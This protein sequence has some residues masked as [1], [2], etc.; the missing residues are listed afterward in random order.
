M[1]VD[2]LNGWFYGRVCDPVCLWNVWQ[3]GKIAFCICA[4]CDTVFQFA[5]VVFL[6]FLPQQMLF[7]RTLYQ[8]VIV[9]VIDNAYVEKN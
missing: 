6:L 7:Q 1:V 9:T 5:L 4:A 8:A 3:Y 2:L